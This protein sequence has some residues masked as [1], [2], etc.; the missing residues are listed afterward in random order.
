M[1]VLSGK[2]ELQ[3]LISRRTLRSIFVD[4]QVVINARKGGVGVGEG[5]LPKE[6]GGR[7]AGG[8]R[9]ACVG[10]VCVGGAVFQ[11]RPDRLTIWRKEG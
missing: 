10:G 11:D 3:F 7:G 6:G 2:S 8:G 9:V 1:C 4:M 5:D